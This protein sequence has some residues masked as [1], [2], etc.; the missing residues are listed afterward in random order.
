[1][2]K[3]EIKSKGNKVFDNFEWEKV[4]LKEAGLVL[5]RLKKIEQQ[6][7][8]IKFKPEFEIKK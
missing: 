5:L 2:L 6:L 8:N 4:T 3:I 1:M 7:I